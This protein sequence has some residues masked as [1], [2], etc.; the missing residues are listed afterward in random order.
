MLTLWHYR[1]AIKGMQKAGVETYGGYDQQVMEEISA[2]YKTLGLGAADPFSKWPAVK[3]LE[4]LPAFG[5]DRVP[6]AVIEGDKLLADV[7]SM[8][9]TAEWDP[10]TWAYMDELVEELCPML[11]ELASY[12]RAWVPG[13]NRY[14]GNPSMV[15][16]CCNKV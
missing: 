15:Q 16:R 9:S 2:L 1:R 8:Q 7:N 13:V 10:S 6:K 12:V 11:G 14:R 4:E 5:L 3:I